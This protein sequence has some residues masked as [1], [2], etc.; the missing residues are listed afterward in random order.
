MGRDASAAVA[1]DRPS[2]TVDD[3]QTLV[4][5]PRP[6]SSPC[7]VSKFRSRMRVALVPVSFIIVRRE[8]HCSFGTASDQRQGDNNRGKR[9]SGS[10]RPVVIRA[11]ADSIVS[12]IVSNQRCSVFPLLLFEHVNSRKLHTSSPFDK[13]GAAPFHA[14]FAGP[15]PE[16]KPTP[17]ENKREYSISSFR[18]S[19]FRRATPS[20]SA[21]RVACQ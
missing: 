13:M 2:T 11:A 18:D 21:Q 8:G 16:G 1:N 5:A 10:T 9:A 14:Q 7:H 6:H 17:G 20:L 15:A 3:R 4:P 19:S 12:S